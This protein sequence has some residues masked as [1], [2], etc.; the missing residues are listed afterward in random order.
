MWLFRPPGVYRPQHDTWLLADALAS[1][2]LPRGA[3]VLDVCAGTG[4]LAVTAGRLGAAEVTAIDISRYAVMATWMN[5]RLQGIPVRARVADLSSFVGS[6]RFDVIVANPPYVPCAEG[7][8]PRRGRARAWNAG[9]RG[10]AVLD[11]LAAVVPL[12][13]TEQGMALIVHSGLNGVETTLRQL[14]GAGLKASVVARQVVPFG[15]VMRGRAEWLESAGLIEPGQ[16]HEELV[17]IRADQL[18]PA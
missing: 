10:R 2:P 4:A 5:G 12:L 9:E 15:P 13:L 14:R 3:R 6:Q 16:R 1:A 11:R 7:G 17:V 18:E 8:V